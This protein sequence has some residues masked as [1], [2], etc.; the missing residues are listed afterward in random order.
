[1]EKEIIR[2]E[3]EIQK[4]VQQYANAQKRYHG[5]SVLSRRIEGEIDALDCKLRKLKEVK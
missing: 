5:D 2:L 1:M 3:K 4:K